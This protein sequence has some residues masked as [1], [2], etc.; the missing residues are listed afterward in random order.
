MF[1]NISKLMSPLGETPGGQTIPHCCKTWAA[2]T[3]IGTQSEAE[4]TAGE[5]KAKT[6][7]IP[8]IREKVL[9]P[10]LGQVA[11]DQTYLLPGSLNLWNPWRFCFLAQFALQAAGKGPETGRP[12]IARLPVPSG[13]EVFQMLD[14]TALGRFMEWIVLLIMILH[15]L[16]LLH[17]IFG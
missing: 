1:L 9:H 6:P 16:G 10:I 3:A 8:R 14:F 11:P 13:T 2:G 15:A 12:A 4:L 7:R 5:I 17:S